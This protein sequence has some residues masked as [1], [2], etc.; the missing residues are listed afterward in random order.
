MPHVFEGV[1][2]LNLTFPTG[3]QCLTPTWLTVYTNS[4]QPINASEDTGQ[5]SQPNIDFSDLSYQDH[6]QTYMQVFG[7]AQQPEL[8]ILTQPNSIDFA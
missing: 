7:M 4:L 2:P 8:Y 5:Y 1:L 3:N 6:V